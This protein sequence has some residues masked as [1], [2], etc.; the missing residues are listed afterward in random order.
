MKKL[1]I[2]VIVPVSTDIK[3]KQCL[4]S[5]DEQVEVVIVLNNNPSSAVVKIVDSDARCK[6]LLIK[7]AGCNLATVFNKGINAATNQKVL[8]TNSDCSFPPGLIAKMCRLL[9]S[10]DVVKARV[11]FTYTNSRQRLVAE[12]R[13]LFHH[14]FDGGTKLFGP[15]LSFRKNISSQLNGYYFNEK[16]SWGEDGELSNR[17]HRAKIK[18]CIVD[19]CLFHGE[20]NI[21]HDLVVAWSIGRGLRFSEKTKHIPLFEILKADW[22]NLVNDPKKR[23]QTAYFEGGSIL[24][25]YL[26]VW[27]LATY[28]GYYFGEWR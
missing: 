20:E 21:F 25:F 18:Y 5:I 13:M 4:E 16:M 28:L 22:K 26:L 9:E 17:I 14:V 8:L 3:I 10:Y 15:G 27:K 12:C 6:V 1:P 19:D 24:A 23:F 11:E 2:S 7:E